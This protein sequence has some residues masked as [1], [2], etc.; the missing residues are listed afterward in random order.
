[1]FE[2]LAQMAQNLQNNQ[3]AFDPAR[4]NDPVAIQTSWRPVKG[5]GSNFRTYK[6]V[7]VNPDRV[8]FRT[9]IGAVIFS[10]I[11]A[12]P[13]MALLIFL[14]PNLNWAVI[15]MGIIIGLLLGLIFASIGGYM[16]YSQMRPIVF[17]KQAGFLWKGRKPQMFTNEPTARYVWLE[18]IHALQIIA[19]YV[20]GKNSFYSFEL[21]LVLQNG[22]RINVIDHGNRR[23]VAEDAEALAEFL[24]VPVWDATISRLPIQ[25]DTKP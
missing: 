20:S 5:G 11:F 25:F 13:G 4:F 18:L 7:K 19:E 3:Y 1:M 17:D 9:T 8:E 2:K 12:L 24:G 15:D 6:L 16:F 10:L 22:N 21:N 14:I 23:R